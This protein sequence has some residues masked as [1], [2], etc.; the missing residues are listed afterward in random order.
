VSATL[1]VGSEPEAVVIDGTSA[2]V[3]NYGSASIQQINL[4]AATVGKPVTVA[5]GPDALAV[6]PSGVDVLV[7]S[8][9]SNTVTKIENRHSK[10]TVTIPSPTGLAY[11]PAKTYADVVTYSGT[12][13]QVRLSTFK[14]ATTSA[15]GSLPLGFALDPTGVAAFVADAGSGDLNEINLSTGTSVLSVA[16]GSGI[17]AVVL[18]DAGPG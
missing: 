16:T 11:S 2:Y 5:S 18:T 13:Q 4:T 15:A 17:D 14:V 8:R 7:G 10:G 6:S 9:T 1:T 12:I 3:A